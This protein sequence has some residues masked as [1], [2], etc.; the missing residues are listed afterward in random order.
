MLLKES[1]AAGTDMAVAV[2]DTIYY[3]TFTLTTDH[4]I[5]A[6]GLYL[7]NG[8]TSPGVVTVS[9][10]ETEGKQHL[11]IG[12]RPGGRDLVSFAFDGSAIAAVPTWYLFPFNKLLH[13]VSGDVLSILVKEDGGVGTISWSGVAAGGY[14]GGNDGYWDATAG[15]WIKG[16]ADLY[17]RIYSGFD[18]ELSRRLNCLHPASSKKLFMRYQPA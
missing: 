16:T 15:L 8:G 2:S 1:F 11:A 7:N 13:R 18:E 10:R 4:T 6:V 14:A 17:F 9:L 5:A 3:Q 12:T